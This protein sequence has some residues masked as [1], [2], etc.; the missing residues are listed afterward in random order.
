MTAVTGIDDSQV[1]LDFLKK[2]TTEAWMEKSHSFGSPKGFFLTRGCEANIRLPYG[3]GVR[4]VNIAGLQ[5]KG[6]IILNPETLNQGWLGGVLGH[7]FLS[8]NSY[9]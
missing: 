4:P 9:Q 7:V 5:A 8:A 3:V 6:F 1:Q 2:N